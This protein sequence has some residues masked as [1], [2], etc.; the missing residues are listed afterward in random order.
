[1]TK[2]VALLAVIGLILF[3]LPAL[4]AQEKERGKSLDLMQDLIG[5][6]WVGH[7][8]NPEDAHYVHVMEWVPVL[9]GSSMRLTKRVDE[10]DFEMETIYFWDPLEQQVHLLGPRVQRAGQGKGD[11][12]GRVPAPERYVAVSV[13][14]RPR[15]HGPVVTAVAIAI[16]VQPAAAFTPST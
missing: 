12:Q 15:V 4:A 6:T 3:V 10:L 7:Y 8:S 13:R 14:V 9:G 11:A 16:S 2:P 5:K 1:M